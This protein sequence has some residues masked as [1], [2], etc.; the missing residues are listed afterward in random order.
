MTYCRNCT[1]FAKM[2]KRLDMERDIFKEATA[3][4]TTCRIMDLEFFT[5][6]GSTEL[7]HA[8]QL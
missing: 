4:F 1:G 3:F 6:H 8:W 2:V 5:Y 7:P